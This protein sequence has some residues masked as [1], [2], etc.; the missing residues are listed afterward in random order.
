MRII[1]IVTANTN[2]DADH[3]VLV[4]PTA[5]AAVAAGAIVTPL[6]LLLFLRILF[7]VVAQ[8]L[9]L[10][11]MLHSFIQSCCCCCDRTYLCAYHTGLLIQCDIETQCTYTGI[12][13]KD[14]WVQWSNI[15]YRYSIVVSSFNG[16]RSRLRRFYCCVVS[17]CSENE[18]FAINAISSFYVLFQYVFYGIRIFLAPPVYGR[19]L[20]PVHRQGWH[21]RPP[22]RGR[23]HSPAVVLHSCYVPVGLVTDTVQYLLACRSSFV[24]SSS[25]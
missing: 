22:A 20:P 16:G 18:W 10:L 11:R 17:S 13:R 4:V 7:Q 21:R 19:T 12:I 5:A 25:K 9:L 15:P 8:Q 14:E 1:I 23:T 6:L 2:E 3:V 24:G